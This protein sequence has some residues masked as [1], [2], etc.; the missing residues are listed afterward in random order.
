MLTLEKL[1]ALDLCLWLR[2]GEEA[3]RR[4]GISQPSVSRHRR[5]ALACF[6]LQLRN[7]DHEWEVLG[8]P[9]H[10]EL[11]D[12]ERHVHQCARWRGLAPLRIEGTYWSGPLLLSPE[13]PGWIGGRH[14]IVGVQRPLQ[15]LRQGVIDAWLAGGPDWPDPEDPEFAVLQLCRMPVHL[16]VAPDHPLLSLLERQGALGWDDVSAFPS[17]A[18]PHGAY[19]KV[20]ASLRRLGLWSSP[21]R[22]GRYR[23]ELWEG[24]GEQEL[25]V[26]YATLLSEQIA[27]ALVRLPLTLPVQSGEALVVRRAW[28]EQPRL[29]ALAALLR[30]RLE[31]WARRHPELE[32][33]P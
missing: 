8:S 15:W 27:G 28:A 9:M 32:I 22:M 20:E 18:L 33:T 7:P 3:A 11:L 24:R 25:M 16:V 14:D 17:L 23:R 29:Q 10:L 2:S 6:R 12:Q 13:P 4:L 31:P 1:A 30:Q 26:A 19:P 5:Q 21:A